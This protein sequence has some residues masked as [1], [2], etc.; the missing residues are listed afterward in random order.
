MIVK[1]EK[2]LWKYIWYAVFLIIITGILFLSMGMSIGFVCLFCCIFLLYPL[3]CMT[4]SLGKTII[5]NEKGCTLYFWKYQRTYKWEE[6]EVKHIDDRR[7]IYHSP[8]DQIPFSTLVVFST[9]KLRKPKI[10]QFYTYNIY[11]HPFSFSFFYVYFKVDDMHLNKPVPYPEIYPVD[12]KEFMEKMQ[13]WGVELEVYNAR[14]ERF[15]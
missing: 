5:M 13:E 8:R 9:K 10:V 15:K 11:F 14:E 2:T 3:L 12:E 4:I 6:F 7:D 1:S